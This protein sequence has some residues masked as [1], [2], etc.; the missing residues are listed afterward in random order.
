[1][2]CIVYI[3]YFLERFQLSKSIFRLKFSIIEDATN[4]PFFFMPHH[5]RLRNTQSQQPSRVKADPT[6]YI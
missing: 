6:T 5:G 4:N 2:E 3:H 1:M